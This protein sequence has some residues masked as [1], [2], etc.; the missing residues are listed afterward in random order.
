MDE[1]SQYHQLPVAYRLLAEHS[2]R[3]KEITGM[4]ECAKSGCIECHRTL[5]ARLRHFDEQDK[6][7]F[8]VWGPTWQLGEAG[9]AYR[10]AIE[11]YAIFRAKTPISL[12]KKGRP[13]RTYRDLEDQWWLFAEVRE[14][15]NSGMSLEAARFEVAERHGISDSTVRNAYYAFL[16]KTK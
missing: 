14:L 5:L 7:R 6:N 10:K 15:M 13:R 2:V 9:K 16:V 3:T 4:I 8:R 11:E 12:R 1:E